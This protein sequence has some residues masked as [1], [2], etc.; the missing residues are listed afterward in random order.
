MHVCAYGEE[1]GVGGCVVM[2]YF[3]NAIKSTGSPVMESHGSD[4]ATG[5]QGD[6]NVSTKETYETEVDKDSV[7]QTQKDKQSKTNTPMSTNVT[8]PTNTTSSGTSLSGPATTGG[9]RTVNVTF[10]ASSLTTKHQ[11]S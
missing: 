4:D 5:Y 7:T 1:E 9:K 11:S 6:D 8:T 2:N 3:T 10:S